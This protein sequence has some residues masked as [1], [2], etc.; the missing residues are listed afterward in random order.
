[1]IIRNVWTD[2]AKRHSVVYQQM[3]SLTAITCTQVP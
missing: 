2:D 3:E 1:M